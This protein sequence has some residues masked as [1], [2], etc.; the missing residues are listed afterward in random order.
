MK[1]EKIRIQNFRLLHNIELDNIPS[2]AVF[3]GENGSGKST[4]FQVFAFLK[5]AL[6]NNINTALQKLGGYDEVATRGHTAEPILIEIQFRMQIVK[7]SRLVTYHLEI[8]K[9]SE[10]KI[11][12]KREILKYK[13]GSHGSPYHFLDFSYG[14]GFAISNEEDFS[15]P[16]TELTKEEQNLS[17]SDILAI[18][19]LGQFS[20]FKAA[21]AFRNLIENW[22]FSNFH[23]DGSPSNSRY[24]FCRTSIRK[25]C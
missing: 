21:S 19:G 11:V 1:I 5:D 16:D 22:H 20:K 24:R 18:K 14:E 17:S 25:W 12:I 2:L 23:T 8:V 10:D 7:K 13:R 15:K 9:D 3:V 4:I 6:K